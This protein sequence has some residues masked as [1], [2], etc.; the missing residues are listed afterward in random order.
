VSI[1]L[2]GHG[3]L[4]V[5]AR[6]VKPPERLGEKW[7]ISRMNWD[8]YALEARRAGAAA[9]AGNS[10]VKSRLC[11]RRPLRKSHNGFFQPACFSQTK[12]SG[13]TRRWKVWRVETQLPPGKRPHYRGNSHRYP[14]G[15]ARLHGDVGRHP[16]KRLGL[17]VVLASRTITSLL[18]GA[19][20]R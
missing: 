17:K 2:A 20:L 19:D 15:A 5:D 16:A 12:P 18:W 6:Q 1:R 14:N 4:R 8:A 3:A 10:P 9:D 11:Y 13:A 7:Q